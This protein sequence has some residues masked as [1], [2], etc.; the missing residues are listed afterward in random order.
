VNGVREAEIAVL[1]SCLA[2]AES[3]RK[4]VGVL[5]PENFGDPK[6]AAIFRRMLEEIAAGRP[7]DVITLGEKLDSEDGGMAYLF[8]VT[9]L[10]PSALHVDHYAEIVRRAW[11]ERRLVEAC[12]RVAAEPENEAYREALRRALLDGGASRRNITTLGGSMAEY[13]DALDKRIVGNADVF[14]TRF[15]TLDRLL[16]GGGFMPGQLVM[17]GARTSRGKSSL[18]LKLALKFSKQ[19]RKVLFLSA[20]MT[21][22]ELTDRLVAM[23]SGIPLS[24]LASKS[25][26][27]HLPRVTAVAGQI[28]RLPIEFSIGGRFTLERVTADL[29]TSRPA[30]VIVDYIQRFSPP[31][32]KESNRA[33]FFSD[34][35][36]GLKSLALTKQVL[37]VTASQLG[38]AVE[39]RD[40]KTPT[41]ADLKESGGL[42][43]AP[44]IVMFL[45][46]PA[47]PDANNRRVGEFILAKQR[48]GPVGKIPAIFSGDTT[49]FQE[50]ADEEHTPF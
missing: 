37:L 28:Q 17:V 5:S 19:G 32:G 36:N 23:E 29:E 42:E 12:R 27:D 49:D 1:G 31:E 30:V 26:K 48:N 43:E 22:V 47:D 9:N 40:E 46:F 45:H 39:F 24:R 6:N 35:A 44:D 10:V 2:D 16:T 14:P 25:V 50:K 8:E 18:L 13:M 21:L 38:R 20:E 7:V 3:L 15:P 34:V 33:A 41:L 4:A 11:A